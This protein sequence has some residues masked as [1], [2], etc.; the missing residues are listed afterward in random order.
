MA[1]KRRI[2]KLAA[3]VNA[4]PDMLAEVIGDLLCETVTELQMY[5]PRAYGRVT[6]GIHRHRKTNP[7]ASAGA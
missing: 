1:P 6:S 4:T 3:L 7:G 5:K 2:K